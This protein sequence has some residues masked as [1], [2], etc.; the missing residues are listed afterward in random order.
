VTAGRL[1]VVTAVAAGCTV[2]AAGCGSSSRPA[3]ATAKAGRN[4]FVAFSVCM[5]S[6]GVPNFPDPG[7]SGLRIIPGSG[8][9]PQSPAFQSANRACARLLP[10]GGT[11]R[12]SPSNRARLLA[13]AQCMRRHGIT[14]FPDPAGFGGGVPPA[15]SIV[16]DGYE[17]KLGAGLD[18]QSPAFQR[19]MA[20]CR[21]PGD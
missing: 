16:L 14:R 12:A 15:T 17:F 6:H 11:G 7:P 2:A 9:N 4:E 5:R 18:A 20:A 21:A 3:S 8:V 1:I 19:A 13:L 10:G